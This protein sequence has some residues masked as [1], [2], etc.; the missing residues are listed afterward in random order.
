MLCQIFSCLLLMHVLALYLTRHQGEDP[1]PHL[2][3]QHIWYAMSRL[4]LSLS[5]LFYL[6]W[7]LCLFICFYI[8]SY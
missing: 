1:D 5:L 7:V 2:S 3:L 4:L 6:F 8:S